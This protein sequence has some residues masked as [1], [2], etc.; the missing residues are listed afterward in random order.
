M[1]KNIVNYL[2]IILGLVLHIKIQLEHS[3]EKLIIGGD[4]KCVNK[5]KKS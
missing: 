2:S 3:N 1:I 4:G 5:L